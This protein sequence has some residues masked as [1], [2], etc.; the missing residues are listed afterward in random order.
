VSALAKELGFGRVGRR[1]AERMSQGIAML[2]AEGWAHRSG[3]K[4]IW[5]HREG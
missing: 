2:L 4:L 3:D 1:V 5:S